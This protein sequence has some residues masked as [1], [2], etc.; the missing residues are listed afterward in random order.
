LIGGVFGDKASSV[1]DALASSSGVKSSSASTLMF[2]LAPLT[3]GVVGR[4]AGSEGLNA[5]GITNLLTDQKR[6]I[7]DATPSEVSRVWDSAVGRF[8]PRLLRP[9]SYT[10]TGGLQLHLV[11]PR[12]TYTKKG[13]LQ[14]P[15]SLRGA[16]SKR[17]S[18][19]VARSRI[20]PVF[21]AE[22][23]P[24]EASLKTQYVASGEH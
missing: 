4:R 21:S 23:S 17:V 18:K 14:L 7:T 12:C 8:L 13:E 19:E 3:L 11:L 24:W 22:L 6:E 16:R 10:T 5:A 15:C 2:L 1:T 9:C 20:L